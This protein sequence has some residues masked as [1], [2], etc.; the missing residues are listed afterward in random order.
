MS[1]YNFFKL[2]LFL[3]FKT[4]F[5]MT[6]KGRSH[7]PEEGGCILASNHR[8]FLDP[9]VLG[10]AAP[11]PVH[12]MARQSLFKV[13]ILAVFMRLAGT[14]P[15][16]RQGA[17]VA[18]MKRAIRRLKQGQI[19]ALFP[20]GTRSPDGCLGKGRIGTAVLAAKAKVKIIPAFIKG[21][22]KAMPKGAK[23]IKP[24]RVS[25]TFGPVLDPADFLPGNP[26]RED[27]QKF[28]DVLM[29]RLGELG[30]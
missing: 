22:Y 19:V 26:G 16:R 30:N 3:I 9:I 23:F 20:E 4:F 27:Y 2:C 28:T 24:S 13:K 11:R 15:V 29:T 14:F 17:D 21:T 18:A 7:F 12:F 6:A 10:V 5:F 25:V 1:F 8:S